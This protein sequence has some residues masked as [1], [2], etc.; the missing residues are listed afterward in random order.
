M[1]WGVQNRQMPGTSG[2]TSAAR[3]SLSRHGGCNISRGCSVAALLCVSPFF[4]I[5]K[6]VA[7]PVP[8][9][10]ALV[11]MVSVILVGVVVLPLLCVS[12]FFF[13]CKQVATSALP[14]KALVD[15]VNVTLVGLPEPYPY[16][17]HTAFLAGKSPNVLSNTVYIHGSSQL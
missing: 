2:Y 13:L 11:D 5:C 9:R 8:P 15:M 6:Q 17:V 7:T 1:E 10:V 14:E 12:P 4:L 16:G 3:S